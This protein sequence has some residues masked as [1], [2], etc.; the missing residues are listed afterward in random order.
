MAT[1]LMKKMIVAIAE[2]ECSPCNG[3]RPT[4]R[5][6]CTT[7][8]NMVVL[9]AADKGVLSNCIKAGLVVCSGGGRDSVVELTNEGF[10]LYNE[11]RG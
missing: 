6:D 5:S 9:D 11:I 10:A 8:T 2:D 4:V 1:E 3:A 7:W